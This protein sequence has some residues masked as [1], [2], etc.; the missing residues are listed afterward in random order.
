M[1]IVP[2][3]PETFDPPL[4]RCPLC[5]SERLA[6][7]DRDWQGR[8]IDR[9]VDCQ[10]SFLNPQYTDAY[11]ARFYAQYTAD[12]SEPAWERERDQM[13][14]VHHAYLEMVEAV[15]PRGRLLSVGCGNGVELWVAQG[16]GWLAEGFDVD[17]VTVG[18]VARRLGLRVRSGNFLA[19]DL[20]FASYDCVYLHHVLEHPKD[21]RACLARVHELLKPGGVLFL[22][23]PNLGSLSNRFKTLA[24]RA[25]LKRQRGKHYDAW[26]HLFFYRPQS[27]ADLLHT[28]GFEVVR[29]TNGVRGLNRSRWP[30]YPTRVALARVLPVL[31][32]IL[33]VIGRR[34][35]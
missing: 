17:P 25:G 26:H 9:C 12:S 21:P 6:R 1:P 35:G 32:S 24:G 13:Q 31:S 18:R 23:C 10:I 34:R 16:R 8:T 29:V 7:H 28:V 2:D 11:L 33:V 5:G 3:V 4:A 19:I 27:L 22:A 14:G 15:A 30:G 20:P